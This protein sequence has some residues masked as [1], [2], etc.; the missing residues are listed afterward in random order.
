MLMDERVKKL[1]TVQECER[2]A[3]NATGKDRPDLAQMARRRALEIR[4]G[5]YGATT[6]AERECLEAIYAYEETLFEKHGKRILA[7]RIC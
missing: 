5:E 2:F 4:A 6:A 1:K 3:K 7:S